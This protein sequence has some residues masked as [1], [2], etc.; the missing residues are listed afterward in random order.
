MPFLFLLLYIALSYIYPGQVFP[1]LAPYRITFLVG[2]IG[3]A[4]SL[5]WLAFKRPAPLATLQ[6]WFLAAFTC[7]AIASKMYA[8]QWFGAVVPA[9]I[10]FGPSIAMFVLT[11]S[12]V[13]S[14]RKLRIAAGLM[15][16][17]SLVLVAFGVGAYHFGLNTEIFLFDPVTRAEYTATTDEY[18]QSS[19]A[20]PE[21]P[22]EDYV[23][24]L[25]LDSTQ[26]RVRGLGNLHDPNDLALGLVVALPLL[27]AW[28]GPGILRS[29][30][31]VGLPAA[32][33]IYGVFM[34]HSRGG[35][36]AL[37]VTVMVMLGRRVGRTAA[38]IASAV[39][40]AGAIGAGFGGGREL[41]A[42]DD[43]ANG[44]FTAWIEGIEMLKTQPVLGVGY[45]QFTEHHE[46][47]AHNSLVLCF[48]ETGLIGY[49]FWLGFIVITFQQLWHLPRVATK[50]EDRSIAHW[51]TTLQSAIIGF[52]T[53]ALFL[54]RTFIPL[55]YLVVG[56]SVAL[57]LIAQKRGLPIW[58]PSL[59]ALG[60]FVLASEAVSILLIYV[61]VKLY[62]A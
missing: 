23:E 36:L 62:L 45:G 11:V 19:F 41:F 56:L 51:A 59:P 26:V 40:I 52:M 13:D 20:A 57:V 33:L 46:L 14:I 47:T 53:A 35:A 25:D 5:L 37:V 61:T 4:F 60:T 9:L 1:A 39:L 54:S 44:R 30:G 43:A 34:T 16:F 2:I 31:L 6:I 49:F 12:A 55:L 58:S 18:G 10:D 42:T 8:E 3:L 50:P 24:S 15:A 22:D 48:A 17:L 29:I 21:V 27:R 32:A 38:I 28:A 7:I